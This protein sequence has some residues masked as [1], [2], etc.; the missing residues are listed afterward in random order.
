MK[1]RALPRRVPTRPHKPSSQ[2]LGVRSLV[3]QHWRKPASLERRPVTYQEVHLNASRAQHR[4]MQVVSSDPGPMTGGSYSVNG[5]PVTPVR[6]R[7]YAPV[8]THRIYTPR[9]L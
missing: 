6:R 7:H 9:R 1:K 8:P 5:G 3:R 4:S 2:A